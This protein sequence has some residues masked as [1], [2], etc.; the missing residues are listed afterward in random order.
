[1]SITTRDLSFAAFLRVSGAHWVSAV[2][3]GRGVCSWTFDECSVDSYA[4]YVSG[5][6]LPAV[7]YAE[8]LRD[9]KRMAMARPS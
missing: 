9:L 7:R 1:M 6:P 3:D 5:A 4:L 2:H 8:A